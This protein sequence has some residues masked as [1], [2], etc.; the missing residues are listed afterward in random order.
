MDKLGLES[1]TESVM[2]SVYHAGFISRSRGSV[3]FGC[4]PG[5]GFFAFRIPLKFSRRFERFAL[6]IIV[7]EGNKDEEDGGGEKERERG[8]NSNNK[9]ILL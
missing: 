6:F 9:K 2:P 3:R 8:N 7:K 4:V 1:R 5:S